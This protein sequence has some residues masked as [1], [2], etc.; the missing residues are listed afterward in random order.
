[1]NDG[2]AIATW[3]QVSLEVPAAI[4]LHKKVRI[5]DWEEYLVSPDTW[6]H[7][8]GDRERNW[9]THAG[10]NSLELQFM[11]MGEVGSFPGQPLPFCEVYFQAQVGKHD[12]TV[13]KIAYRIVTERGESSKGHLTIRMFLIQ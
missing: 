6:K 1:M 9:H 4:L 10:M 5:D 3:F 13:H 11:S 2:N 8:I 12:P 7:E